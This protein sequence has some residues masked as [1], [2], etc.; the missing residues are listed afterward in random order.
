MHRFVV[1]GT[2]RMQYPTPPTRLPPNRV[3][4]GGSGGVGYGLQKRGGGTIP[5]NSFPLSHPLIDDFASE[6]IDPTRNPTQKPTG[7]IFPSI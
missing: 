7:G 5:H 4:W 2:H 1:I 3:G 6:L